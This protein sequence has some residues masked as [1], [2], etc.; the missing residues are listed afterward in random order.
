MRAMHY[1]TPHALRHWD[2]IPSDKHNL[3]EACRGGTY[4]C[5]ASDVGGV[6]KYIYIWLWAELADCLV[7]KLLA[8][9]L[10]MCFHMSQ[11][12]VHTDEGQ[13]RGRANYSTQ[14]SQDGSILYQGCTIMVAT[15][16]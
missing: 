9:M 13:Q 8:I 7:S 5:L 16:A 10:Q 14:E 4:H 2:I 12:R 3:K 1:T 11:L 15:E 6:G